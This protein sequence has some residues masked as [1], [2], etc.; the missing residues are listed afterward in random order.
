MT[1]GRRIR[2][3][4]GRSLPRSGSRRSAGGRKTARRGARGKRR[5]TGFCYGKQ[6]EQRAEAERRKETDAILTR[7]HLDVMKR[8][9]AVSYVSLI[10]HENT[11]TFLAHKS[12]GNWAPTWTTSTVQERAGRG[13]PGPK[14]KP[15]SKDPKL[16][17]GRIT[18]FDNGIQRIEVSGDNLV[19]ILD[20]LWDSSFGSHLY[21]AMTDTSP[22]RAW[23]GPLYKRFS[24]W[25]EEVEALP[26]DAL[27]H[28]LVLDERIP[29]ADPS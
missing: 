13:G 15:F 29:L 24:D 7:W 18:K 20:K 12:F 1:S 5:R 17:V 27:G 14:D 16:S 22:N 3:R 2:S 4:N 28:S 11:W 23:C 25:L 6:A 10:C 21:V 26:A 9:A 19:R 8:A